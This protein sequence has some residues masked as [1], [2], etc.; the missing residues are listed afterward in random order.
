MAL[1]QQQQQRAKLSTSV[2]DR[3]DTYISERQQLK[4]QIATMQERLDELNSKITP[5]V[6]K[7]G[8]TVET[9]DWKA[10]TISSE[11]SHIKKELLLNLGVKASI[12]AKATESKPYTYV[13]VTPKVTDNASANLRKAVKKIRHDHRTDDDE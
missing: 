12:I 3:L 6:D 1:Q 9:D 4:S 2:T 11:S 10:Q 5:L 13:K 8:G 7:A